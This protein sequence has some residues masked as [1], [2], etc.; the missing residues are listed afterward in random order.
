MRS[1]SD[2]GQALD[3]K[4]VFCPSCG[5]KVPPESRP[6]ESQHSVRSQVDP[7]ASTAPASESPARKLMP[8]SAEAS[9]PRSP[10]AGT[11]YEVAPSKNEA[12]RL[13]T[14]KGEDAPKKGTR[15]K[16]VPLS[17]MQ[18]PPVYAPKMPAPSAS[19][20]S[21]ARKP[22]APQVFPAFAPLA[23][24]LAKPPQQPAPAPVRPS[25]PQSPPIPI[26]GSV[27]QAPGVVM[28][29]AGSGGYAPMPALFPPGQ[30]VFV[31]WANGQKYP[32]VV[33][34]LH[35]TQCL[36][37]FDAGEKRWVETRFVFPGG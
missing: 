17:A 29:A 21:P 11:G 24:A 13:V 20:S 26:P 33:E 12:A 34:Q 4:A 35:G 37:R 25:S 9:G 30:R 32:G 36:V 15:G 8:K 10:L 22:Q 27:P 23:Q 1:C 7:L 31:Q 16:T 19:P 18:N 5:K 2:C 3:I 14:P 28:P 6:T